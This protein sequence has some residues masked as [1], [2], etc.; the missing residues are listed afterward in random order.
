MQYLLFTVVLFQFLKLN[1]FFHHLMSELPH[2]SPLYN[3]Y[4]FVLSHCS[5]LSLLSEYNITT[6][7]EPCYKLWTTSQTEPCQKLWIPS[8]C[9]SFWDEPNS[10]NK[11]THLTV[12]S[13]WQS[14]IVR[15]WTVAVSSCGEGCMGGQQTTVLRQRTCTVS[16]WA[17]GRHTAK[18]AVMITLWGQV[19]V[20]AR[21]NLGGEG[22]H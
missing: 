21:G 3:K 13:S 18:T 17:S 22:E 12:T 7:T 14:L 6:N 19:T 4:A 2:T 10:T 15:H 5:H 8:Q 1:I 20:L 9:A 11:G 16:C